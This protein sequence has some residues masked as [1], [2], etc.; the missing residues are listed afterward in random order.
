MKYI[1]IKLIELYQA[2]ISP[3]H[4]FF[5]KHYPYGFCRFYPSCSEYT[6][7]SIQKYGSVR[8]AIRGAKRILN[9]NPYTKPKV[10]LV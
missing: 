3:D 10:D 5:R 6:K 2:T 7:L 8:G 4:G 1:L 9:C